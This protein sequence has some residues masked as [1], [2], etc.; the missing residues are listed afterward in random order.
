MKAHRIACA[1]LLAFAVVTF[2]VLAKQNLDCATRYVLDD[3]G[4]FV[5]GTAAFVITAGVSLLSAF[6]GYQFRDGN[7]GMGTVCFLLAILPLAYIFSNSVGFYAQRTDTTHGIPT[8]LLLSLGHWI[9]PMLGL[10]YWPRAPRRIDTATVE[11]KPDAAS[12]GSQL[13]R[14]LND[15]NG[16]R[17]LQGIAFRCAAAS[18][19]C[20]RADALPLVARRKKDETFHSKDAAFGIDATDAFNHFES[21]AQSRGR[22]KPSITQSCFGRCIE[23]LG[24]AKTKAGS[25]IYVGLCLREGG[26]RLR[27]LPTRSRSTAKGAKPSG[28]QG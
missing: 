27:R 14:R 5:M 25:Y 26:G 9:F 2:G 19:S 21:W 6:A 16:G 8:A 17:G 1:L 23:E 28:L 20:S 24:V 3:V 15:G 22:T 13:A 7:K 10:K 4:R 12:I 11:I 18:P